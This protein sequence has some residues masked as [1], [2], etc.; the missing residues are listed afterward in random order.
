MYDKKYLM[1]NFKDYLHVCGVASSNN[2]GFG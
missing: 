2:R 1:S